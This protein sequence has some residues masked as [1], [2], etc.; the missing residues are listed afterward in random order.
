M[1]DYYKVNFSKLQL[2]WSVIYV[3]NETVEKK[4]N[5]VCRKIEKKDQI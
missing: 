2:Q 5:V 1:P 4:T 3:R